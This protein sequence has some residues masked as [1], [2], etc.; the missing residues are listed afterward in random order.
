MADAEEIVRFWME[1]VGP[2]K[3]YAED[4][5]LDKVIIDQF[6]DDRNAAKDGRLDDWQKTATGSLAL[7]ILL[8][9]FSRNMFRGDAE[10]FAADPKAQAVARHAIAADQDRE[11]GPPLKQFFFVPFMHSEDLSVMDYGIEMMRSRADMP[12]TLF[13]MRVH[14]R[15]IETF[16]RFPYR[17]EALGRTSSDE[18]KTFIESGGYRKLVEELEAADGG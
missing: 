2:E 9:Q 4:P 10:S 5:E 16:G 3:W 8:D 7:L 13:H 15:I 18:E 1:D 11:I 12:H 6:L 17:N 14:R